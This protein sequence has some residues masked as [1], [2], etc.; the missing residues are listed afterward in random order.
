MGTFEGL[1][2]EY[3]YSGRVFVL[4]EEKSAQRRVLKY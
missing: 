2:E 3:K 1:E 4:R